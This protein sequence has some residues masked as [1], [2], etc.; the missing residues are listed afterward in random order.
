MEF[1]EYGVI[2]NKLNDEYDQLYDKLNLSDKIYKKT[3]YNNVLKYIDAIKYH[4]DSWYNYDEYMTP[5]EIIRHKKDHE[6]TS[7]NI[8]RVIDWY[9]SDFEVEDIWR[10]V[11][12]NDKRYHDGS[13]SDVQYL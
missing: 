5:D 10:Y 2:I 3:C 6:V 12:F 7:K 8:L 4:L 9:K 11:I 1:P 13:S